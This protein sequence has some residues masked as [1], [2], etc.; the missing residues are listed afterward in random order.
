MSY[1]FT[2]S[3]RAEKHIESAY[4]WYEEQKPKLGIKFLESLEIAFSSIKSNP[5]LYSFRKDNIRRCIVKG[6]P[7]AV[8]FYVKK[9]NIR[10]TAV[11]HSSRKP[12]T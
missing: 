6:F 5:L 7:Y 10:V 4:L 1:T 8:L 3:K 9:N 12:N 11:F 2:V